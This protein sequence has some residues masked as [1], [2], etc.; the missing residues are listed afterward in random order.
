MRTQIQD[1]PAGTG[2][3][4]Y[5]RLP[6]GW[7]TVLHNGPPGVLRGRCH[8]FVVRSAGPDP[9]VLAEGTVDDNG[10]G[11]VAWVDPATGRPTRTDHFSPTE[12]FLALDQ[13][14]DRPPPMPS[15]RAEPARPLER[16]SR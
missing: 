12:P 7:W 2:T 6:N 4:G 9:E 11:Y 13:R 8:C 15:T 16:G 5:H 1:H 3:L 14:I 10:C